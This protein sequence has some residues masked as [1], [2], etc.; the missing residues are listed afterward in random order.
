MLEAKVSCL[1]N[2]QWSV[3]LPVNSAHSGNLTNHW[4]MNWTQ[5]KD[6][7]SHICLAGAVVASWS[8]TQEVA[9]SSPS[10]D[11]Y[12][13]WQNSL[14]SV[15]KKIVHLGLY[16]KLTLTTF[17]F[18]YGRWEEIPNFNFF[19]AI[20]TV[21]VKKTNQYSSHVVTLAVQMRCYSSWTRN[22]PLT[23]CLFHCPPTR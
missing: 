5:F 16:T 17:H 12:F 13:L 15:R 11:K 19:N 7:V 21:M 1:R 20:L 8:L 14:N 9:S 4:C 10:N 22:S 2:R 3:E 23:V 6:P 18:P